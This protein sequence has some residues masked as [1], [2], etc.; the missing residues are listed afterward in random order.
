V[1]REKGFTLIELLIVMS[2]IG[3]FFSVS[4]PVSM[5]M[6]NGFKASSKAQE[7]MVQ[8]SGIRRQ[9][10]L[11]GEKKVLTAVNGILLVNDVQMPFSG[12]NVQMKRAI[13]FSS[14]GTT[15]GGLI[16]VRVGDQLYLVSVSAPIGNLFLERANSG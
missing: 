16:E 8:I 11:Y 5:E 2:I 7:I 1:K 13:S 3:L 14:N 10:F 15:S 12:V 9:A 6:Y 4:L